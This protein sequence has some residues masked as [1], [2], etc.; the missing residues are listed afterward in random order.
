MKRRLLLFFAYCIF[1]TASAQPTIAFTETATGISGAVDLVSAN[2]G[3]NRLFVVAQSGQV[4]I[5]SGGGI[6]PTPFL[7][8]QSIILSG[9]ERGLLSIA[10]HPQ[11]AINRYFFIYYNN[12][13][14]DITVAQYRT[15]AVNPDIADPLSGKVLL[16]IPKPFSNHN[17]GKLNFGPD[18]NLYF[19][20][21]DG[22]SSGDPNNNAQTGTSNLGKLICINVDNFTIPPYYTIPATN[23]F[24]ADPLVNDEI[25]AV[26]LRNPWRWSFDKLT[27]DMW[28]ADVGQGAWEEVNYRTPANMSG[29][30]YGWRCLEGTHNYDLSLCT[31]PLANYAA[32]VFEYPHNNATGGFSITGGYV[33]RGTE[34]TPLQG[35]YI[36]CDYVTTN[37]WLLKDNGAGGITSRMQSN[38]PAN[39]TAFGQDQDGTLYALTASGGINKII[40][41]VLP[42]QLISFT[43]NNQNGTDVL[44]WKINP[45]AGLSHFEIE[46]S[47]D[48]VSFQTIGNAVTA[49]ATTTYQFS[50][51]AVNSATRFYRLKILSH[52][53]AVQYSGIINLNTN[54]NK[55]ISV[56]Y[57]GTQQ[58]QL[59]TPGPLKQLRIVNSMGQVVKN[60]NNIPAGSQLIPTG[61]LVPAIYWVQCA[62][63]NG[64]ENFKIAVTY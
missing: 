26:G 48:G 10:F 8:V 49:S 22:G 60:Y 63:E 53:G 7:N 41:S 64:I 42:M 51:P 20:T 13:A 30:N 54:F 61:N 4:H 57:T 39:V 47:G 12:T 24:I 27:G 17:G 59:Y 3:S 23:P 19:G 52:D 62:G 21:G 36:C 38:F 44:Q 25:F 6:L 9:G 16:N 46:R 55:R 34:F 5:Y 58:L 28:I 40:L 29:V 14:G 18:G 31:L 56:R 43:A 15:D 35:Y 37:G 50:T 11:Y 33:Y 2:D 1:N 32:P 45:D